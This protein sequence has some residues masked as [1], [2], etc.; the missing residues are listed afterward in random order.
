MQAK[1]SDAARGEGLVEDSPG[2]ISV[3]DNFREHSARF[4]C[5]GPPLLPPVSPSQ[6]Y[7]YFLPSLNPN[8][9]TTQAL[10]STLLPQGVLKG[11]GL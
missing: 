9:V 11:Q 5:H 2:A 6:P 3:T 4:E 10:A 8:P 1:A 7:S